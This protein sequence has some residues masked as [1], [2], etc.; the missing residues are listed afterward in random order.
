MSRTILQQQSSTY[1]L[2]LLFRGVTWLGTMKGPSVHQIYTNG[3]RR[4]TK[5]HVEKKHLPSHAI[6][7]PRLV[8]LSS[9]APEIYRS[10]NQPQE[11]TGDPLAYLVRGLKGLFVKLC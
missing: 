5:P 8:H 11:L 3:N 4:K 10:M 2:F 7:L 9:I 6:L 1:R